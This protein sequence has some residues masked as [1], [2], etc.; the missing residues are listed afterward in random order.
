MKTNDSANNLALYFTGKIGRIR[1][2]LPRAITTEFTNVPAF[3]AHVLLSKGKL[4]T[5]LWLSSFSPIRRLCSC[6]SLSLSRHKFPTSFFTGLYLESQTYYSICDPKNKHTKTF[7]WPLI[8]FQIPLLL[9]TA[10]SSTG[11][12]KVSVSTSSSHCSLIGDYFNQS[13]IPIS[14][15]KS[16]HWPP[17]CYPMTMIRPWSRFTRPLIA[18]LPTDH[19]FLLKTLS[20]LSFQI[21]TPKEFISYL[22]CNVFPL[23]FLGFSPVRDQE[24]KSFCWDVNF[25]CQTM[26][27]VFGN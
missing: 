15:L 19:S 2:G 18:F 24:L 5:V 23:S 11:F 26:K 4:S 25:I 20:S 1:K 17:W 8:S 22:T 21:I 9:F 14:P 3:T 10:K 7:S 16:H 6:V 27:K 13:F 12:F